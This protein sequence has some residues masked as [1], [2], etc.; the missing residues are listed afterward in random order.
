MI[1]LAHRGTWF[2]PDERN[3]PVAFER[4][5]A[6]GFGVE[7]DVRDHDGRLVIA[8]DPPAGEGL[9]LFDD[10]LALYARRGA[11]G[12]LAVNVKADGLSGMVE[13]A[14]ARAGIANAFVFDMSAPETLRYLRGRLKVF[15]RESEYE[16]PPAFYDRAQGVWLDCFE[17]DWIDEGAVRRHLAAGK[18]VCVVSPE[19]HG[20]PHEQAWAALR[21]LAGEPRVMLCTDFPEAARDYFA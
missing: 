12:R 19:L 18:A 20:R 8:H 14:L 13:E 9:L 3:T 16:A 4:A 10:L 2:A 11:P 6:A 17:R 7:T 15:T 1:I 5:F 21:G